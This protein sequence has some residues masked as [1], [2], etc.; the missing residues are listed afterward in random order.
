MDDWSLDLKA[1]DLLSH[2][3]RN[4]FKVVL[5]LN[6]VDATGDGKV[7][8]EYD[9]KNEQADQQ[10]EP[11]LPPKFHTWTKKEKMLN[12]FV[13]LFL[14]NCMCKYPEALVPSQNC[15]WGKCK[16]FKPQNSTVDQLHSTSSA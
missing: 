12:I 8:A 6:I 2:I 5:Y 10:K 1:L 15:N 3:R 7:N 14:I 16:V 13:E 9:D 11:V 4:A